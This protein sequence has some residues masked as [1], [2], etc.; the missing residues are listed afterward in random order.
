MY[1][2]CRNRGL[3]NARN[4]GDPNH[5]L[6][7]DGSY[8]S[9]PVI[10]QGK[11]GTLKRLLLQTQACAP[12][13]ST[14]AQTPRR[15]AP[16]TAPTYSAPRPP[17]RSHCRHTGRGKPRPPPGPHSQLPAIMHSRRRIIAWRNTLCPRTPYCAWFTAGP[18]MFGAGLLIRGHSPAG[19]VRPVRSVTRIPRGS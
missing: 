9:V 8:G 17:A 3:Y 19:L 11:F 2:S 16:A 12:A 10:R 4:L 7:E 6:H 13:C 14:A 1:A 18:I 5:R 15:C